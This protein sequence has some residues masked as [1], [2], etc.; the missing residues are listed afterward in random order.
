[1]STDYIVSGSDLTSIANSIREKAGASD[2]L[3]FPAGFAEAIAGIQAGGSSVKVTTGT[4]VPLAATKE[5]VHG[6]G[7]IP[8]YFI[9]Y[10]EETSAG[11]LSTDIRDYAQPETVIG[12]PSNGKG[13]KQSLFAAL[14]CSDR[15]LAR[16][17][18]NGTT[19]VNWGWYTVCDVDEATFSD[20]LMLIDENRLYQTLAASTITPY[21]EDGAFTIRWFAIAGVVE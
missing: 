5:I 12:T 9:F 2:A 16:T 6:L 1:M 11:T 18:F 19:S 10:I 8:D 15:H 20:Y 13:Y 14:R 21:S 7:V 3:A 17:T 4:I